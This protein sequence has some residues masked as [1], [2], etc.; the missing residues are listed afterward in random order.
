MK[1]LQNAC[2]S[3]VQNN[4]EHAQL[5]DHA[6]ILRNLENYEIQNTQTFFIV[7][8]FI[9]MCIHCLGHFHP[10]APHLPPPSPS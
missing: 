7:Y 8:S 2:F 5:K 4:I 9:H 3:T 10:P 6:Q 1:Y